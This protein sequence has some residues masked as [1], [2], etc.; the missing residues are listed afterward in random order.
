MKKLVFFLL[1]A[2][3]CAAQAAPP[4]G[5]VSRYTLML[6]GNKAGY[7]TVTHNADGSLDLYYEF[8]DRGRGPKITEHLVLDKNG[9]PIEIHNTGNDYLKAPVEEHFSVKNGV[10]SWKN[11]AEQ[12]EAKF[13][14]KAFYI[15]I[16][17]APEEG[18][19]LA[20]AI[21]GH[22][23]RLPLLPAGEASIE[24]RSELKVTANDQS[25]TVD[26]YAVSGLDFVPDPIWLD[27]K[28]QMFAS[29]SGWF[30][31]V[32]EGWESS[33]EALQRAQDDFDNQRTANLAKTLAHRPGG[34]LAFVHANLFD[35]SSATV[36]PNSTVVIEG[37]KITA[38]GADG[39]VSIPKDAQVI[40][41]TN[42]T[43]MP[44]LWDMH[45]HL[46]PND[47]LLN[48]A[49]GIT[50]VRDLGNDIDQ[51]GKMRARYQEGT[52]I[53]P[54]VLMA[55]LIDGRGPYAGPTKVNVDTEQEAHDNID[56]FAKL[57]YVQIKIYSSIK[58][59][60]VPKIAEIAHADGMRVSG[61][62]PAFMTAEQF[63]KDGADEIQ[64]MNFI[65]LNFIFDKVKDTR[66]PARFT[67]VAARGADIDPSS[68]QVQAFIQLLQQHKTV[69]DPTLV[70]FEGMFTDRPGKMSSVYAPVGD[71]LPAQIRR[72]FLYGGLEVPEG[73]DQR[74]HDS[75]QQMLKMT[76]TL[77]DA[78]IPIVAGTDSLAGFTLPRELEL[79]QQAGIPAPKVLQLATLGA[80]RVMKQEQQ[81]GS[82][83][84]GKLADVILVDGNP[85]ANVGDVRKVKTVIK[86]GVIYQTADLYRAVGVR[87]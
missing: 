25:R 54:R 51:L 56:R 73:M 70:V 34:P 78:G 26:Q 74:Y 59:E 22:G 68:P 60:L 53:G 44:G 79:Y 15:S 16:S 69:V 83:E 14:G 7:E 41:A 24:R 84:V 66:T 67:E 33:V 36:V 12:G 32:R 86:D 38:I 40:D 77:Y 27:E 57:G 2:S 55:G 37:N 61:H 80:A 30:V 87:P 50:S 4:A 46:Q 48:I 8:N 21:L 35:S 49:C 71:R 47:G 28:G 3:F 31:V 58:P 82:I 20:K 1:L 29:L 10:A 85:A 11:R 81:R 52:E 5:N 63:V 43:L 64:H 19:V 42:Q 18:A 62:V 13:S 23:G 9:L 75:F 17:G 72:G 39:K 65:F 45:V 76:K 6:A